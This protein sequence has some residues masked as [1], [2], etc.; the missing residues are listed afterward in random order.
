M[1]FNH[2]YCIRLTRTDF[3][4]TVVEGRVCQTITE[5]VHCCL[6]CP[7]TEWVY[8]DSFNTMTDVAN[9]IAAASVLGCSFLL[10]SWVALPVEKT[11]R[12]YLSICLTIAVLLMNVRR[13][14]NNVVASVG[15]RLLIVDQYSLDSLFLWPLS[16]I[17]ASTRSRPIACTPAR[18]AELPG[19]FLS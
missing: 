12:H 16:R 14:T 2:E 18:S 19:P 9:W 3:K 8:P 5:N 17:N 10:M 4:T 15:K 1:S 6:P 11:N 13:L 7:M